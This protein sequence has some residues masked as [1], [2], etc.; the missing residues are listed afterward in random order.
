MSGTRLDSAMAES[1]TSGSTDEDLYDL[2]AEHY[3]QAIR[4]L[5]KA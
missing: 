3:E 4:V 5:A 1:G 2:I